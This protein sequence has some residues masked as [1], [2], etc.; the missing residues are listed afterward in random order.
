LLIQIVNIT[1]EDLRLYREF[2]IMRKL[3]NEN[4]PNLVRIYDVESENNKVYIFMEYC[5]GGDL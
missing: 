4:N 1:S 2:E 3:K 5:E